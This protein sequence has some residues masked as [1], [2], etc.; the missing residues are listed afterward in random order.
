VSVRYDPLL[1]RAL[2]AELEAALGRQPLGRL[3]L[4]R[5]QRAAILAPRR[6]PALVML[7]HPE[8]GFLLR[9][10]EWGAL[11]TT[12]NLKGLAVGACEAP[13]DERSISLRLESGTVR[14]HLVLELQT[15][16]WNLVLVDDASDTIEAVLWTRRSGER[17]LRQGAAYTPS[18]SRRRFAEAI[19]TLTE[20][21]EAVAGLETAEPAERRAFLLREIACTSAINVD[22]VIGTAESGADSNS[23]WAEQAWERYAALRDGDAGGAMAKD[24]DGR[25]T[26]LLSR[27]W[28]AQPYVSDLGEPDATPVGSVLDGLEAAFDVWKQPPDG[29]SD[30]SRL[31]RA[32]TAQEP[33]V[34]ALLLA[35]EARR[36]KAERRLGAL[37]RELEKGPHPEELR[38]I[39]NLL[40]ARIS[41]VSRGTRSVTLTDFD[42]SQREI[43]LDP[44]REPAENAS[45]Y[46][47]QAARRERA[48]AA[49]PARIAELDSEIARLV[50]AIEALPEHGVSDEAWALAGGRPEGPV[51]APGG[52]E[53]P[54][55]PYRRL[56][57]SGGL[58]VR[59]GRGS[60]DNDELTF[61]HSAPEDVWLHARQSPG[62]HV[63]LRWGRR[64]ENPPQR[65]LIEAAIAAAV[66]SEAR[67]SKTVAVDWTRR[68]HVRKPRK[69][70]LGTVAPDRVK[71]LFVEPDEALLKRLAERSGAG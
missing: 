30:R 9:R 34:A 37:R 10:E 18:R 22:H 7:L 40:L 69:A 24:S 23:S 1:C 32:A 61:R 38:A 39:G 59:I 5:E 45:G 20:W 47:E 31:A 57:T 54:R 71:T 14:K 3:Y 21:M 65:D 67:H 53:P 2:A 6:G 43:E 41:E 50:D 44:R 51:A 46:Y 17:M 26:H 60:R 28:G 27:S 25:G 66:N 33:E 35:L 12:I 58:E 8:A 36:E 56:V 52:A 70:P 62:A 16:Q 49:L 42:G 15:N 11:P 19:P 63:I 68:K 55:L 13:P 4:D 29:G 64:D 48:E